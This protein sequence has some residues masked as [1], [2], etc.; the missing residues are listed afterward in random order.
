M[1]NCYLLNA[2]VEKSDLNKTLIFTKENFTG[3]AKAHLHLIRWRL[4]DR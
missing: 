2:E 4:V 1:L 3:D